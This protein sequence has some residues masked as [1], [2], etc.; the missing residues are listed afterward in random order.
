ML[1]RDGEWLYKQ[2]RDGKGA[3]VEDEAVRKIYEWLLPKNIDIHFGIVG[4]IRDALLEGWDA[5]WEA[6]GGDKEASDSQEFGIRPHEPDD[7]VF[8]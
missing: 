3:K 5:G 7:E 1:Q 4:A 2:W 8:R 6:A